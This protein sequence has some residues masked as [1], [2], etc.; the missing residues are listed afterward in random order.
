MHAVLLSNSCVKG[1]QNLICIFGIG[2]RLH[3]VSRVSV[4]EPSFLSVLNHLVGDLDGVGVI[5]E[6]IVHTVSQFML[7]LACFHIIIRSG[8]FCHPIYRR[9]A[10]HLG[11][12]P[13]TGAVRADHVLKHAK[14]AL[15]VVANEIG[16]IFS[17]ALDV[18]SVVL[19]VFLALLDV[20][21]P[22][23]VGVVVLVGVPDL[24]DLIIF[25]ALIG[26]HLH[27]AGVTI[28]VGLALRPLAFP[29]GCAGVG[30]ALEFSEV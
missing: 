12:L 22:L 11:R 5:V 30:T 7:R 10:G 1:I 18:I 14:G 28:L 4:V 8:V 17:S 9:L 23:L 19:E 27:P 15:E 6:H 26:A 2:Q 20:P 24:A 16:S 25:V 21:E 29:L 13:D 3:L